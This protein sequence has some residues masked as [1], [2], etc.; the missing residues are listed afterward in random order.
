[1]SLS[2]ARALREQRAKLVADAQALIPTTGQLT[3]EVRAQFDA[4][5]KDADVLKGDIDRIEAAEAAVEETRAVRQPESRIQTRS[6]E[7]I[8]KEW[9]KAFT[10]YSINGETRMS[11]ESRAILSGAAGQE[12]RDMGVGT[13]NL[14]GFF[15]PQGF[16]YNVEQAMAAYGPML[17]V[18]T[19]TTTASG[20]PLPFPTSNDTTT[21]AEITAEAGAVNTGD[22]SIGSLTINAYKWDS[23]LVKVSLELLQDSAFDIQKFLTNAFGERF[24]RGMNRKFTIGSGTNEPK[25]LIVAATAG[26]TATGSASNTGGTETGGTTIGSD[27][28]VALEGSVDPAYRPGSAFMLHDTT[29]QKIKGLRDKQGHPIFLTGLANNAPDTILGYPVYINQVMD[30]IAINKKTIAFGRFDKY[31]VRMVEG[32]TVLRLN[33]LFAQNGQVG[34]I[35]FRRADGNLLDAGTHPVKYLVQAAA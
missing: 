5:M 28:L 3:A 4:M 25:G 35:A 2:K 7:V 27:D 16:V 21:E 26:P 19:V 31:N 17:K 29:L 33:E 30:Q 13:N 9:R 20:N 15:V 6:K 1:M 14:G 8:E 11:P 22:V 10:D 24:G 18:A 23:K 12:F 32:I 34:F